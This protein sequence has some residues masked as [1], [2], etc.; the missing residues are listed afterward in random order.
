MLD[1]WLELLGPMP[2]HVP[3]PHA[4]T[5]DEFRGNGWTGRLMYL[6]V[7]RDF[8]EK[9]LVLIPDYPVKDRLR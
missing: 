4:E 9:I 8:S 7:E 3:T 1:T 2:E 6:D 5:V